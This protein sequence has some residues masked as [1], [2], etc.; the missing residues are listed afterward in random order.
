MYVDGSRY[1]QDGQYH[2]GFAIH[3]DKG[4]FLYK[5]P[6]HFSAQKAEVTAVLQTL[7]VI[8]DSDL[9]IYS[10]SAFV[11]NSLTEYLLIWQKGVLPVQ[12]VNL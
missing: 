11:V 3:S 7:E 6:P 8:S 10:D 12:M 2:T 5:C 1:W 4:N 9:N